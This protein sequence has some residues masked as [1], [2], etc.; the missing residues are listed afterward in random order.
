MTTSTKRQRVF[1]TDVEKINIVTSIIESGE[2]TRAM[3]EKFGIIPKQFYEWRD[4]YISK[5]SANVRRRVFVPK[6]PKI[7]DDFITFQ[8]ECKDQI[9]VTM[10]KMYKQWRE[11]D[12]ISKIKVKVNSPEK[13]REISMLVGLNESTINSFLERKQPNIPFQSVDKMIKHLEIVV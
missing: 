9:K 11:N 8:S 5:D 3:C 7:N 12:L 6:L 4:K 2:N 10:E 13:V 1:R